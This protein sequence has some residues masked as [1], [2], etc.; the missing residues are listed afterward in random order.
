[1][2]RDLMVDILIFL[3][4]AVAGLAWM[5]HTAY[6]I[7]VRDWAM[8]VAGGMSVPVG[9]FHGLGLWFGLFP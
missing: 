1:M 9:V 4:L 2:S 7:I 8:L 3:G 5:S 6:S